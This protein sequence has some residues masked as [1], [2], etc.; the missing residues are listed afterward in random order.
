MPTVMLTV[1]ASHKISRALIFIAIAITPSGCDA[2]SPH[3]STNI[4][5]LLENAHEFDG[6]TIELRSMVKFTMHG[7]H[8][9]GSQ[10]QK[11][12]S[13]G[14]SIGEE[15]YKDRKTTNLVREAMSQKGEANVTLIGRFTRKTTESYS[16]DFLLE[17]VVE[18]ENGNE[19][20]QNHSKL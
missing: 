6:K 19:K 9:F 11:L 3:P 10:C 1:L 8:L 5:H 15:K 13:L 17:E 20:Q 16:G 2:G 12:G 18:I 4:C 7:R 14:L